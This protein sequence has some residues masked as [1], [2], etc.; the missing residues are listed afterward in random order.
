MQ[1]LQGGLFEVG[2]LLSW[3][4]CSVVTVQLLCRSSTSGWYQCKNCIAGHNILPITVDIKVPIPLITVAV[5]IPLIIVMLKYGTSNH[6][7][8]VELPLITD[9]GEPS[10]I[11]WSQLLL[12]YL[13]SHL[14]LNYLWSHLL[15][16]YLQSQLL[17]NYLWSLYCWTTSDYSYCWTTSI[18]NYC[19][20]TSDHCIVELTLIRNWWIT[21]DHCIVELPL[22][23][24]L[25]NNLITVLL[26]YLW[27]N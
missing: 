19:W 27:S 9:I 11:I 15:L 26:S 25:L 2:A 10:L 17:L 16:N 6:S 20:T 4:S 5:K 21:S 1:K 12:N 18:H 3:S 14:L 7:V 8:T 13:W 24:V 23:T 22:I